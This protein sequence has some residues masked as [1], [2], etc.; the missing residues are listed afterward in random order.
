MVYIAVYGSLR[1][2]AYNYDRINS[3]FPPNNVKEPKKFRLLQDSII[4][5]YK[6]FNL[7]YYPAIVP[8]GNT[9]DEIIVEIMECHEEPYAY[10]DAMELGAGYEKG[11]IELNGYKCIF[12]YMPAVSLIPYD[13]I[14]GGDWNKFVNKIKT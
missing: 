8:T 13:E 7:G 9:S 6:M 3:Y 5:G 14:P 10:I 2:G 12:Y 4:T 1:V 11:E